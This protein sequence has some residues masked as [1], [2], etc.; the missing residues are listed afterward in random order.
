[1]VWQGN[2]G[3]N[4]AAWPASVPTVSTPTPR[5]S[6]SL[7]R[8]GTACGWKPG[9]C[10]PSAVMLRNSR[11]PLR[12][13][14]SVRISTHA[15]DGNP[16]V[17]LLPLLYR[18]TRDQEVGIAPGLLRDIDDARR[19]DEAIDRN[20]VRRV[21]RVVLAGDPVNGRI[22]MRAGVLAAGDVVPVPGGT[23]R[24]VA[25]DFLQRE[26]PGGGEL[27]RQLDRR[28]R[29]LQRYGEIHHADAAADDPFNELHQSCGGFSLGLCCCGHDFSRGGANRCGRE[30]LDFSSGWQ[31]DTRGTRTIG[32]TRKLLGQALRRR[33]WPR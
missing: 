25:R 20:V 5:M 21:V 33:G 18:L 31:Y 4:V 23:A 10:G 9:V 11:A 6:R 32:A 3:S 8:N 15:C 22:E 19:T 28:R 29:R 30:M 17:A 7:A 12:C 1:M 13:D 2:I 16:A 26:G 24:V 14:Q 27:W